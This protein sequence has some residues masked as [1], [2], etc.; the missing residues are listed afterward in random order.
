MIYNINKNNLLEE[1]VFF[2][3][4]ALIPGIQNDYAHAVLNEVKNKKQLDNFKNSYSGL[5]D[6]KTYDTTLHTTKRGLIYG[7]GTGAILGGTL[8]YN[9]P[10]LSSDDAMGIGA[11]P[12]VV[13]GIGGAI[14]GAIRNNISKDPSLYSKVKEKE[15]LYK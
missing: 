5:A 6:Y 9:D 11:I 15:N 10:E 4:P 1:A 12:A 13:G 7:A 3:A 14:S 8:A 2:I